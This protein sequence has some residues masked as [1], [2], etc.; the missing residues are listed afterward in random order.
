MFLDLPVIMSKVPECEKTKPLILFSLLLLAYCSYLAAYCS[1]KFLGLNHWVPIPPS[2]CDIEV[3][4]LVSVLDRSSFLREQVREY[5][6]F[7]H[8]P[9]KSIW[10]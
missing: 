1:G 3:V 8:T 2:A 9:Y 5:V 10:V 7:G 6:L 4:Q